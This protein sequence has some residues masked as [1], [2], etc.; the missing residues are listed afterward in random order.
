M[1]HICCLVHPPVPLSL[2]PTDPPPACCSR[3]EAPGGQAPR[4]AR[5]CALCAPSQGQPAPERGRQ[6]RVAHTAAQRAV[7]VTRGRADTRAASPLPRLASSSRPEATYP[8]CSSTHCLP[9]TARLVQGGARQQR[10]LLVWLHCGWYHHGG[11]GLH[12]CPAG[13]PQHCWSAVCGC[14]R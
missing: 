2:R 12:L 14:G 6:V 8:P 13:R 11:S 5:R 7:V 9:P 3:G 10:Q 4:N 1:R